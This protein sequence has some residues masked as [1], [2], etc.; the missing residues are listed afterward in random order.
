MPSSEESLH[1]SFLFFLNPVAPGY[2]KLRAFAEEERKP[3]IDSGGREGEANRQA[4][5]AADRGSG[6][7]KV[8]PINRR[9]AELPTPP[10]F[11]SISEGVGG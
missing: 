6:D 1:P 7:A 5:A 8:R 3:S 2:S 4:A 9:R 11:G 10:G